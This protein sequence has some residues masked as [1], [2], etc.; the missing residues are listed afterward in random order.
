[1]NIKLVFVGALF[2]SVLVSSAAQTERLNA[3]RNVIGSIRRVFREP[4]LMR[5]NTNITKVQP[6]DDAAWIW[7][8][9][10]DA[11]QPTFLKFRNEFGRRSW[12]FRG[13]MTT[14]TR[15]R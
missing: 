14:G 13:L 11:A 7:L 9:G 1:M 2:L 5:G 15:G 3:E 10:E 8:K 4:R 6:I 12:N